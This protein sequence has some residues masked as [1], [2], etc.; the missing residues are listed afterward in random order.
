LGMSLQPSDLEPDLSNPPTVPP[1]DLETL[2]AAA[3]DIEEYMK[4]LG[5]EAAAEIDREREAAEDAAESA[6]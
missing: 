1:I 3:E 6:L 5:G 4:T 2:E